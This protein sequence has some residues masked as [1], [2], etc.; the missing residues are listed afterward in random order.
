MTDDSVTK[1]T[2][3]RL[4]KDG[5]TVIVG[6]SPETH[7]L[8]IRVYKVG[9][10]DYGITRFVSWLELDSYIDKGEARLRCVFDEIEQQ[11]KRQ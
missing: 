2:I 4:V 5:F 6:P 3:Q 10:G 9:G 11:L 8:R 1:A 7:A